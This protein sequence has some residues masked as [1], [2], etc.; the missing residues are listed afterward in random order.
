MRKLTFI[1]SLLLVFGLLTD[2]FSQN[3]VNRPFYGAGRGLYAT[4]PNLNLT[5]DQLTKINKLRTTFYKETLPIR[6]DLQNK[7]LELRTL[8]MQPVLNQAKIVALQKNIATIRQKLQEKALNFRIEARKVLTPEQLALLP[9][10]RGLGLGLGFNVGFGYGTGFG[11]GRGMKA[12]YGRGRGAGARG[13][14]GYRSAYCPYR[15]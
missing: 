4:N 15:F 3:P 8:M 2:G 10:G 11:N 5:P 9:A 7:T 12:G 13:G 1:L 14:M 6:T